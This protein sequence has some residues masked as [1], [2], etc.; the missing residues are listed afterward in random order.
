MTVRRSDSGV[1][2][3]EGACAVEDAEPL[4]RLLQANPTPAVDWTACSYLHTAVI[5]V[6]LASRIVPIGRCGDAWVEQWLAPG[7]RHRETGQ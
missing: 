3:I 5:Q 4:L 1:A 6:I 2:M 7:L